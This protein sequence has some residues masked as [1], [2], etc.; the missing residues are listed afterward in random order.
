MPQLRIRKEINTFVSPDTGQVK[1][2]LAAAISFTHAKPS[3]TSS[4]S[5]SDLPYQ[6]PLSAS[7]F[8]QNVASYHHP[9]LAS[10]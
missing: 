8:V 1:S 2:D 4:F 5:F 9:S 7:R 6:N 10:L 3:D